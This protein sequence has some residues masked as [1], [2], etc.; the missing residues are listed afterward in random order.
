MREAEAR[1]GLSNEAYV[2]EKVA[3]AHAM[4]TAQGAAPRTARA[5]EAQ[6]AIPNYA[7]T[8]RGTPEQAAFEEAWRRE[9]EA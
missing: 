7:A 2:R 8:I 9:Q 5:Q 4:L 3:I 1:L 6:E